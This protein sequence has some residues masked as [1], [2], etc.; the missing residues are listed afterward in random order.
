MKGDCL[1][2]NLITTN[3]RKTIKQQ[4]KNIMIEDRGNGISRRTKI[5]TNSN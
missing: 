4:K 2:N 3:I 5:S 1:R